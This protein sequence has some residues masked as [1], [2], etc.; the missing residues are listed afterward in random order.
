M[1]DPA[2]PSALSD[3]GSGPPLVFLHGWSVDRSFFEPQLALAGEGFRVVAPDLA[4]HGD[5]PLDDTPPTITGLA[6]D[7]ASRLA[8]L[9]LAP[10]VLIGWSMGA[11]VALDLIARHGCNGIAGLV[12]VDMTPK[13]P[14]GADWPYGLSS[15]QNL[16]EAT[17]AADRMERDWLTYAPKIA[18]AMF[19]P[20]LEECD[21]LLVAAARRIAARDPAVMAPLWRSLVTADHRATIEGLPIPVLA[22]AGGE[23]QLYRSEVATWIADHA[24]EGRRAVIP[25]AGHAPHIEKADAFN[26]LVADFAASPRG[27]LINPL[28]TA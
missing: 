26:R 11:T 13:V 25:G 28:P 5:R 10:A 15:G 3:A 2:K 24:P 6:D 4:G 14:N 20:G 19:A 9:A 7:L 17:M 23:S 22:V 1:T 16:V 21:P 27:R 18:R 12:I 8:E